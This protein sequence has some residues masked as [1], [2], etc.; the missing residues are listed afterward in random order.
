MPRFGKF[1]DEAGLLASCAVDCNANNTIR[2]LVLTNKASTLDGTL[3]RRTAEELRDA[4]MEA[5][6]Q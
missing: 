3:T 2:V 6:A 5:L 4:I 1:T